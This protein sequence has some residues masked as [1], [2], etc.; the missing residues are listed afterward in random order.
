[1]GSLVRQP[2]R[3]DVGALSDTRKRIP[4]NSAEAQVSSRWKQHSWLAI[5]SRQ[6]KQAV[7]WASDRTVAPAACNNT[8]HTA[9]LA[10]R[11]WQMQIKLVMLVFGM[12]MAGCT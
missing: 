5:V 8:G 9:S 1:M 11:R 12:L 6:Q 10:P 7:Q 4:E 2:F 3:T